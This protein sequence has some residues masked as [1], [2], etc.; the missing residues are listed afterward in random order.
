MN[1]R[2]EFPTIA[3]ESS[4]ARSDF[5]CELLAGKTCEFSTFRVRCREFLDRQI[6][7][8]LTTDDPPSVTSRVSHGLYS[9]CPELLLEGDGQLVF[10][11]LSDPCR[12]LESCGALLPD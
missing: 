8:I 7:T 11:L 4:L 12:V 10:R 6:V 2:I 5:E 1:G 9:F 3:M